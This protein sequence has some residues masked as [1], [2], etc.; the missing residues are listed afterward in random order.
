M[1]VVSVIAVV[2]CLLLRFF[3]TLSLSHSHAPRLP[4]PSA[5]TTRSDEM[6]A[7]SMVLIMDGAESPPRSSSSSSVE[8][9]VVG[10]TMRQRKQ[11]GAPRAAGATPAA[12]ATAL[13]TASS[14]RRGDLVAQWYGA[15]APKAMHD[16]QRRFRRSLRLL[17]PI[18]AASTRVHANAAAVEAHLA[19]SSVDEAT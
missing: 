18:A 15:C 11:K 2:R 5:R 7:A 12:T 13:S 16:A 14:A 9:A 6:G 1:H 19:T 4:L 17:V 10:S 3:F 8:A